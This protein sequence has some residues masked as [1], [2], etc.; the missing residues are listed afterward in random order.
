ARPSWAQFAIEE[1]DGKL[2]VTQSDSPVLVYNFGP[3]QPPP[4]VDNDRYWRSSYIHPLYG[5][6]GNILTED[7]PAD[8]L[9]HRGVFW[10]W[11]ETRVGDRKMDV[12][13]IVGARQLFQRWLSR[14]TTDEFVKVG[15]ENGWFF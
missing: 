7:F 9:H 8:H 4:G 1:A 3:V 6:D 2:R 14:E 5:L 15:V 11:P 10:T 13:T 12:W